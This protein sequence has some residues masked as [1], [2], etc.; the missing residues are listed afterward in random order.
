VGRALVAHHQPARLRYVACVTGD[1][2]R[3]PAHSKQPAATSLHDLAPYGSIRRVRVRE[4][5]HGCQSVQADPLLRVVKGC[6]AWNRRSV[7]PS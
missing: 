7:S 5:A 3:R 6:S 1:G 2:I 4:D